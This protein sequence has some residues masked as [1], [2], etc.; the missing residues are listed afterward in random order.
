MRRLVKTIV[1][2][3]VDGSGKS[4][5]ALIL[6]KRLSEAEVI[7]FRWRALTLYTLYFYSRL[8]GLYVK[9]YAPRIK[10]H[11][12]L[13]V[14]HIDPIAKI[15]YPYL[16]YVDLTLFYF[17][18]KFLSFFKRRRLIIFDRFYLDALVDVIHICRYIKGFILKLF[19]SMHMRAS[20]AVILDADADTA[21][22]RKKDII[23]RE[24]VGFKRKIYLALAKHLNIPI[25]DARRGLIEVTSDV[26][27]VT[28]LDY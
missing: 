24:E 8:R 17:L 26:H 7:W 18:H 10:R 14:F 12:C 16:L 2:S 19:I 13:H 25:I 6:R 3:G 20:K 9:I 22:T 5:L 1:L 15:L 27:K 28:Q 4:T 23:S 21:L 11:V